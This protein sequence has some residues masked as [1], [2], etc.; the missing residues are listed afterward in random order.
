MKKLIKFYKKLSFF[1]GAAAAVSLTSVIAVAAN[2]IPGFFTFSP[3]TVIS[4]SQINSNFDKLA[5]L[6]EDNQSQVF[7]GT[8]DANL[9]SPDIFSAPP[10]VGG[11]YVV[12]TAGVQNTIA[13]AV[14]DWAIWNGTTWNKIQNVTGVTSVFG[15]TGVILKNEGDYDINDLGDVN[16]SPAPINGQVLQFDG[17]TWG[18]GTLPT[19]SETDPT[20]MGFA[21]VALP[22]CSGSESLTSSGST[23]ICAPVFSSTPNSVVVTNGSGNLISSATISTTHLDHLNGVTSNI[24]T[25][26]NDKATSA[27]VVDW[28]SAGVQTIEP[29]RINLMTINRVVVTN[30]SGSPVTSNTTAAELDYLAGAT[31][32]IQ[33]QLNSKLNTSISAPTIGSDA[34]NKAYADA[35]V[36]HMK[37]NNDFT[38]IG[39]S[40]SN[41]SGN[42]GISNSFFGVNSGDSNSSGSYNTYMGFESGRLLT[43]GTNNTAIGASALPAFGVKS[44]NTAVGSNSLN[45]ATVGSSNTAVGASTLSLLTTGIN[46]TAIGKA[47]GNAITTGSNNLFVGY[48][49][50]LSL[51]NGDG[52]ILIGNNAGPSSGSNNIIIGN[53]G[54]Q[55]LSGVN[56]VVIGGGLSSLTG[57]NDSIIFATAANTATERMRIDQT[58]NVGIGTTTPSYRLSV[59]GII[60][61]TSTVNGTS[62]VNVSDRRLKKNIIPISDALEKILG[63]RG[64]EFDWK[65]DGT[66]E[67]GLIAQEVESVVPDLVVTHKTGLKAVKYANIV[68][69]LIESTKDMNDKITSLE[70]ENKMLKAYLCA[71]DSTAPFCQ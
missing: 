67:L 48:A 53:N 22:V 71:K 57:V 14:G 47:A 10:M 9:N 61:S 30:I 46:N 44:F 4:S 38:A 19:L 34:V 36:L 29:S 20:V 54:A 8:W 32:N 43:T 50:G 6:I 55:N 1:Q 24:Q 65:K 2:N 60:F 68:S 23:L 27:S 3:G 12:T 59:D 25:Q 7:H 37:T 15:R 52:N 17:T 63:L 16:L 31:S 58:G 35:L 39:F 40:G 45:S 21:K 11:Y 56:N 70:N 28:S 64:V 26:L 41:Y 18:A 69:L 51:T 62:F 42:T 66:H 33:S 13:Y 49:A 5:N